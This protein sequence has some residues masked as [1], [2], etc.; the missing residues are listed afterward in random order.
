MGYAALPQKHDLEFEPRAIAAEK[1]LVVVQKT[2]DLWRKEIDKERMKAV[3]RGDRRDV[4]ECEAVDKIL[5]NI[6]EATE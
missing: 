1:K 3:V 4:R 6:R 2:I 5:L